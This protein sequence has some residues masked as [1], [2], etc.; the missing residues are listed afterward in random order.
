MMIERHMEKQRSVIVMSLEAARDRLLNVPYVDRLRDWHCQL[1]DIEA[2]IKQV[3]DACHHTVYRWY[4]YIDSG[5]I[6]SVG[7]CVICRQQVMENDMEN[8]YEQ[9]LD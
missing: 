6:Q 8:D 2:R 9:G 4:R 1:G 7:R 3:Q 5:N